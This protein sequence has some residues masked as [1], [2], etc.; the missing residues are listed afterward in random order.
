MVDHNNLSTPCMLCRQVI[1]EFFSIDTKIICISQ[2]GEEKEYLVK[3]L[4]PFPFSE[5]DLL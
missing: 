1:S 2:K 4:C 5:D 3:E